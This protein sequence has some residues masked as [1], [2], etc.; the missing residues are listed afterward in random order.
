MSIGIAVSPE[1]G[2]ERSDLLKRADVAMYRSKAHGSRVE[3]YDPADDPHSLERLA[4]VSD[5]RRAFGNDQL[6]LHHQPKLDLETGV[7]TGVEAL[8]RWQHPERGLHLP[9]RV[10]PARRALRARPAR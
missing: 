8:V 1:H 4:L 9:R 7:I 5:L 2:H 3:L 6:V 10:H